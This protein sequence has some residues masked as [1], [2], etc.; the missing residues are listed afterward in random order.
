MASGSN[1]N[2]AHSSLGRLRSTSIRRFAFRRVISSWTTI[3]FLFSSTEASF[4]TP[5]NY[6]VP[7]DSAF[8]ARCGNNYLRSTYICDVDRQISLT[9]VEKIDQ[10]LSNLEIFSKRYV[11]IGVAVLRI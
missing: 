5:C 3:F 4:F 2:L 1:P 9:A 11:R 10:A 7:N 8:E 6:P